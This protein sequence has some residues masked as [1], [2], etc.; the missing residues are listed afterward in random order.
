MKRTFN[1]SDVKKNNSYVR[2]D[3][4][5]DQNVENVM[6]DTKNKVIINDEAPKTRD[7]KSENDY[8][9]SDYFLG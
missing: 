7:Q 3:L 8:H 4:V 2:R 6:E 5:S 1:C 9:F